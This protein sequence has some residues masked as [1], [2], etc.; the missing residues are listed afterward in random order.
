[1]IIVQQKLNKKK[2][3][4]RFLEKQFKTQKNGQ[5]DVPQLIN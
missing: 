3:Q 1:M 2:T 5:K 4:T